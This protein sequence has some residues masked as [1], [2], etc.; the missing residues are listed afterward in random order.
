MQTPQALA[1]LATI[2]AGATIVSSCSAGAKRESAVADSSRTAAYPAARGYAQLVFHPPSGRMY[3]FGG[4]ANRRRSLEET[5]SYSVETNDWTV[6]SSDRHPVNAGGETAA[7][8]SES[9]RIIVYYTTRLDRSADRGLVRLSETWAFDPSTGTWT[10]MRPDSAPFGLMGALMVYDAAADRMILFG[11]ADF[12]QESAPRFDG[13]WAYDY[14]TNTWTERQP[15][16]QPPGRSY[17]GMVYDSEADKAL[18]FGGTVGSEDEAR[19]DELW[20]YDFTSDSW[21]QLAYEGDA[22][23]DHHPSMVYAAGLDRTLYLVRDGLWAFDYA[24][25]SWTTLTYDGALGVRYFHALAYDESAEQLVL[26]GGGPRGLFYDNE[27]WVYDPTSDGWERRG[28]ERRSLVSL[29]RDAL[30]SGGVDEAE[31]VHRAYR[32]N[33]N[34]A[35][36]NTERMMNGFGYAL[37]AKGRVEHAVAMFRMNAEDY[38]HSANAF[39]SLGDGLLA[40][41]DTTGAI[42]A[43]RDA[44]RVDSTFTTSAENLRRLGLEP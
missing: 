17:F 20:A 18:V 21:E 44:L 37:L 19:A 1:R 35:A 29:L 4:E 36:E 16:G 38:P 32:E 23:A 14:N 25:H 7:Y 41:G 42:E 40:S 31:R 2:A 22:R 6:V 34:G 10:D 33:P 8:D 13:T 9:D 26:F 15:T 12:T 24:S 11:G 39:D 3:L 43:W 28:S 27:T 30:S 5:W